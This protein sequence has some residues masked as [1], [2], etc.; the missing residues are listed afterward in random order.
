MKGKMEFLQNLRGCAALLVLIGH[1][2]DMYVKH[3]NST[4]Y[5]SGITGFVNSF[6]LGRVGVIVFFLITGFVVP[7]SLQS[8]QGNF[9]I[10]QFLKRIAFRLYPAFWFSIF[11]ALIVAY[12]VGI[13]IDS[14]E[15]VVANFTM[16][17]KYL[18][19]ESVQGAYWTLHLLVVFYMGTAALYYL[20]YLKCLKVRS[21]V[22]FAFCLVAV[23]FAFLRFNYGVR[24]PIV[25]PLGLATMVLGSIIRS[26]F[27][28]EGF[29]L[30]NLAIICCV[31]FICLYL[32][33][34]MYYKEGWVRWFFPYFFGVVLF[35]A[36]IY[37]IRF[38]NSFLNFFG[39]ISYSCYL[40]HMLA[41]ALVFNFMRNSAYSFT[42]IVYSFILS[43]LLTLFLS[44]LSYYFFEKLPGELQKKL[45][46]YKQGA[47]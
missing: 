28:S 26:H 19:Y 3:N 42:G 2:L 8:K 44:F 20:G 25:M 36:F 21:F 4:I 5:F 31:Y 22:L 18:G 30:K 29:N 7:F 15:Q 17:P 10:R 38:S 43:L 12:G 14:L 16:I 37:K 41:L 13:N 6:E 24:V 32:A 35:V 40:L 39:K 34:I 9:V 1:F 23:L 33:Q 11:V 46:K 47:L 27:E 45:Y